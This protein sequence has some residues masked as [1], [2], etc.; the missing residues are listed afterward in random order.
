MSHFPLEVRLESRAAGFL[1]QP[2][3][4]FAAASFHHICRAAKYERP[5]RRR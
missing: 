2:I 1:D 3:D 5:R 4:D